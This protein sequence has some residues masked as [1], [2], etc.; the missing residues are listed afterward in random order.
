MPEEKKVKVGVKREEEM[1][2]KCDL[3]QI[4]LEN[5]YIDEKNKRESEKIGPN[6]SRLLGLAVL[7]CLSASFEFC[8]KKRN[9]PLEDLE[10]TAEV[11]LSRTQKGF[12]RV[13]KID[14]NIIPKIS[15]P[16]ALKRANQCLKMFEQYC[17]VT[18]SVRRGIDVNV[19]VDL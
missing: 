7:G 10:A 5:L 17:I 15:D 4:K 12:W 6:P 8:L 9:F 3:G 16:D 13:K 1:L 2:F 14:C 11:T 19:N 18:E